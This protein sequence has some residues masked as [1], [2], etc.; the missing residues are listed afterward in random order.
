MTNKE[1]TLE[2]IGKSAY[3]SIANMVAALQ[4]NYDQLD[5]LREERNDHDFDEH[6]CNWYE[7]DPDGAELLKN[8]ETAAGDCTDED[9][10][11]QAIHEDPLSVCVRSD[12][13]MLGEDLEPAE[14][15][16]LL[17]TGG[18]ATRIVGGLDQYREPVTARLEVQDWGTP[19]T[20][21]FDADQDVLLAYAACFCFGG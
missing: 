17:S 2:E 11:R 4:C 9:D 13:Q 15:E 8:L 1:R 5:A 21:Y 12:W 6:G 10:A 19:W 14:F 18:P 3:D 7:H 16:I 20:Q